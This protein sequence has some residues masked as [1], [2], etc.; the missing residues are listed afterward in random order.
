MPRIANETIEVS[1][2]SETIEPRTMTAGTDA[3]ITIEYGGT[4]RLGS[5]CRSRWEA[6]IMSSRA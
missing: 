5:K 4:W 6:K 2:F 3:A 1:A